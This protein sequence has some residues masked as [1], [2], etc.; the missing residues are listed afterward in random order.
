MCQILWVGG[1]MR[2]RTPLHALAVLAFCSGA[3]PMLIGRS[4][5]R[6]MCKA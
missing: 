2:V 3:N 5:H 1:V 6:N 4:V